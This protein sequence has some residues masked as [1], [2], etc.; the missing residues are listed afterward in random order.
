MSDVRS[1]RHALDRAADKF[2]IV[3]WG[4]EIES[5]KGTATIRLSLSF[6][7]ERHVLALCHAIDIGAQ[8]LQEISLHFSIVNQSDKFGTIENP[9]LPDGCHYTYCIWLGMNMPRVFAKPKPSTAFERLHGA[10]SQGS[11][12]DMFPVDG[13]VSKSAKSTDNEEL[14]RLRAMI[15][16]IKVV[17]RGI[18]SMSLLRVFALYNLTG[19]L[20]SLN[21]LTRLS[22]ALTRCSVSNF[23]L[24]AVI[25]RDCDFPSDY[26]T[27]F[28]SNL[29]QALSIRLLAINSCGSLDSIA[30]PLSALLVEHKNKREARLWELCLRQYGRCSRHT[31]VSHFTE[32]QVN[33]IRNVSSLRGITYLDVANNSLSNAF[34]QTL[35]EALRDDTFVHSIDLSGNPGI[36]LNV[37]TMMPKCDNGDLDYIYDNIN[38]KAEQRRG[39]DGEKYLPI[40]VVERMRLLDELNNGAA[41]RLKGAANPHPADVV[42]CSFLK[43]LCD[44]YEPPEGQSVLTYLSTYV[45]TAE[46][47]QRLQCVKAH[48]LVQLLLEN[49]TLLH[50]RLDPSIN[51]T[52]L[53]FV[54]SRLKA[55]R[56]LANVLYLDEGERLLTALEQ[57]EVA[58]SRADER[59]SLE[60]MVR[61]GE[62]ADNPRRYLRRPVSTGARASRPGARDGREGREA[63]RQQGKAASVIRVLGSGGLAKLDAASATPHTTPEASASGVRASTSSQARVY[64][65]SAGPHVD[66]VARQGGALSA[67]ARRTS[68]GAKTNVGTGTEGSKGMN[69]VLRRSTGQRAHSTGRSPAAAQQ[70]APRPFSTPASARPSGVLRAAAPARR[71]LMPQ[72]RKRTI[73]AASRLPEDRGHD[74]LMLPKKSSR[75]GRRVLHPVRRVHR[76]RKAALSSS[77]KQARPGD[78]LV[79]VRQKDIELLKATIEM[80]R[81]SGHASPEKDTTPGN[82][83]PLQEQLSAD[84]RAGRARDT[85][86]PPSPKHTRTAHKR[87]SY[88]VV[89]VSSPKPARSFHDSPSSEDGPLPE[90]DANLQF[91]ATNNILTSS[92][93]KSCSQRSNASDHAAA[94]RAL[95][96]SA[97]E[98]SSKDNAF[99]RLLKANVEYLRTDAHEAHPESQE[100]H[101]KSRQKHHGNNVKEIMTQIINN[102]SLRASLASSKTPGSDHGK[103]TNRDE[104]VS[105]ARSPM[106]KKICSD[107]DVAP[108]VIPTKPERSG[109]NILLVSASLDGEKSSVASRGLPGAKQADSSLSHSILGDGKVRETGKLYGTIQARCQVEDTPDDVESIDNMDLT[110]NCD[111]S[112][113]PT[114]TNHSEGYNAF[115]GPSHSNSSIQEVISDARHGYVPIDQ[116]SISS[117][118]VPAQGVNSHKSAEKGST[119]EREN[120]ASLDKDLAVIDKLIAGTQ[121]DSA[122]RS[123]RVLGAELGHKVE[124]KPADDLLSELASSTARRPLGKSTRVDDLQ[125]IERLLTMSRSVRAGLQEAKVEGTVAYKE[126]AR[127][128]SKAPDDLLHDIQDILNSH[129]PDTAP[130][131]GTVDSLKLSRQL[132]ESSTAEDLGL[133]ST[134]HEKLARKKSKGA[135]TVSSF[136]GLDLSEADPVRD[137]DFRPEIIRNSKYLRRAPSETLD[138]I[139][140]ALYT[141]ILFFKGDNKI[142]AAEFFRETEQELMELADATLIKVLSGAVSKDDVSDYMYDVLLK[143]V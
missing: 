141:L 64:A 43:T 115:Q 103:S 112:Y 39:K 9:F 121:R 118:G 59:Q 85:V 51:P 46:E 108:V 136:N 137:Y 111:P 3:S 100:A 1:W 96:G 23:L 2:S 87:E 14:D 105:S 75:A 5:G 140:G 106:P 84:G 83:L 37:H 15:K 21:T 66:E 73:R 30:R 41:Q 65:D 61:R 88:P 130:R 28:V 74:D 86:Y 70:K 45:K 129:G 114:Q 58:R 122:V 81:D 143:M 56:R 77:T 27:V 33:R 93:R 107:I 92:M 71:G 99:N 36:D 98:G 97:E 54:N 109:D 31:T 42:E 50:L 62:L 16:L 48:P 17:A 113:V 44:G 4:R 12:K 69:A 34:C 53:R 25:L 6:L 116:F 63:G 125:D 133:A 104:Q 20:V 127:N 82:E 38:T 35:Y 10:G 52:L 124:K 138:T 89:P 47:Y 22:Q 76:P 49:S 67:V 126:L 26:L 102:S 120:L 32:E 94:N 131:D 101:S 80:L 79:I 128:I 135:E 29:A 8:F 11:L 19:R 142:A 90:E 91:D 123:K 57:K 72:K 40:R 134:Q 55:N 7:K 132:R 117:I 60:H 139:F 13:S 119:Q 110:D 78:K 95:D 68:A 18:P 24:D